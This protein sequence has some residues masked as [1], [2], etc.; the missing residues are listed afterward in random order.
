MSMVETNTRGREGAE[1]PRARQRSLFRWV[2]AGSIA[3]FLMTSAYQASWGQGTSGDNNENNGLT[4]GEVAAIVVGG[5]AVGGG[6][7]Y[8]LAGRRRR[9]HHEEEE[10]KAQALPKG[11]KVGAL[12]LVPTS[13]SVQAGEVDTFDLQ[14]QGEDGNWYTV[15]GQEA[16]SL[17]VKDGDAGLVTQDGTK[18]AFCLPLTAASSLNGKKVAVVGRYETPE[19]KTL[20]A[21][22][23]VTLNVAPAL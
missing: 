19:G 13:D 16:A 14:A 18:N 10:Q 22:T 2:A 23:T 4:S 6:L 21:E 15:T 17:S 8:L 3:T 5:L 12:K 7:F 1:A 11:Q 20:S 9:H